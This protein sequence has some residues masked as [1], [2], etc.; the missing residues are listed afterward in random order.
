[1]SNLVIT[2]PKFIRL[3][4]AKRGRNRCWSCLSDFGYLH[5]FRRYSQSKSCRML[6]I[7]GPNFFLGGRPPK[8][9]DLDYKIEHTSDQSCGKVSGQLA[10][11]AW[12]SHTENKEKKRRQ[13]KTPG[14]CVPGGLKMLYS[15]MHPEMLNSNT[16]NNLFQK[17]TILA[18][19]HQKYSTKIQMQV[20][21]HQYLF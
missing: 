7:F 19:Y 21:C 13:N 12:R 18:F 6:H 3:F 5:P 14:T 4:L 1:M 20:N 17:N 10:E 8:Y 15:N 11:A 9:F 16:E 2:G